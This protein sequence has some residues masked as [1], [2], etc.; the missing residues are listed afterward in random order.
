MAMQTAQAA[1]AEGNSKV[2][3]QAIP[4]GTRLIDIIL[5][6]DFQLDR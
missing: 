2:V 4:Q 5:K 1:Q 6:Q 3:L